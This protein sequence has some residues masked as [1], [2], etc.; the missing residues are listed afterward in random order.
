MSRRCKTVNHDLHSSC[1][2]FFEMYQVVV[3]AERN[4]LF[5]VNI[6]IIILM[7]EVGDRVRD[8]VTMVMVVSD[9]LY[10]QWILMRA[11]LGWLSALISLADWL[12]DIIRE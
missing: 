10:S 6:S 5:S 4:F 9:K 12:I 11:T 8:A 2:L 3:V 7:S 1:A